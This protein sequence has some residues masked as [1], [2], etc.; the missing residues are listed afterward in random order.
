VQN[1]NINFFQATV[2]ESESVAHYYNRNN[3][4]S[5]CSTSVL[6]VPCASKQFSTVL[7]VCTGYTIRSDKTLAR[8]PTHDLFQ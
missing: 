1:S 3:N 5:V 4:D 2:V 6:N 7:I 8:C